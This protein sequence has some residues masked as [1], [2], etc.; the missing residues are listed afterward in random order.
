MGKRAECLPNFRGE[1]KSL[2]VYFAHQPHIYRQRIKNCEL[3]LLL[4][5]CAHFPPSQTP[6]LAPPQLLQKLSSLNLGR[7]AN[8]AENSSSGPPP[9][10]IPFA[11]HILPKVDRNL[12]VVI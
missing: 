10:N 8:L 9:S 7:A 11:R 3:V 4:G 5:E 1:I 12:L 6:Y 2:G